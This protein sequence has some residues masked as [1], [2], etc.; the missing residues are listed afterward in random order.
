MAPLSLLLY[1]SGEN[2][3]DHVCAAHRRNDRIYRDDSTKN[4]RNAEKDYVRSDGQAFENEII[5]AKTK[6]VSDHIG[7]KILGCQIS[8]NSQE[9]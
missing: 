9:L 6:E 3:V 8:D 5:Y 1:F 4:R 7:D 2:L